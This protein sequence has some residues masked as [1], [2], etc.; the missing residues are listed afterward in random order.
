MYTRNIAIVG[1]TGY[2][3]K[4]L[5]GFLKKLDINIIEINRKN[6]FD[7][8]EPERF[9]YSILNKCDF[10]IVMAAIS[11]PDFC[12]DQYEKAYAVNVIGT[13]YLVKEAIERNCKVIFFSSDSVYGADKGVPFDEATQTQAN[14][15]YGLMKK[16]IEDEFVSISLFKAIRLSY[17]ISSNDKF[18]K[19]LS[20][21]LS[22]NQIAEVFH[23]FYRNCIMIDEVIESVVWLLNNWDDF[24]STFLNV[25]GNELI[26]RVNIADEFNR[27][28]NNRANYKIVKPD[29]KFFDNRPKT[30]EMTSKYL[31]NILKDSNKSFS[32]RLR[33]Q[34]KDIVI[35]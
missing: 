31:I 13:K 33:S 7:L 10:I 20:D 2:I 21:C 3:G 9:D 6:N 14:T 25:C 8:E 16:E 5:M 18:T 34:L 19:Y 1:S 29:E 30:T 11:S 22:K 28:S 4:Q 23:P 17:V 24:E 15:A 26:S 12:K 32:T 35:K 27:I